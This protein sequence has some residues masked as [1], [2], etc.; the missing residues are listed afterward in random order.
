[1]E[2]GRQDAGQ[3]G[4]QR[5]LVVELMRNLPKCYGEKTESVD[6]HV[7]AFDDYLEIQ[8]INV[9]DVNVAQIITRCGYSLFGKAKKEFNQGREGRP[10]WPMLQPVMP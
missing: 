5:M 2:G 1:M 10:H 8:Q 3:Q 4:P 7:D 6:N 9:V